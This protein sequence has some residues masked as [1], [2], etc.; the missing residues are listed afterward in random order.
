[1]DYMMLML[2]NK[3]IYLFYMSYVPEYNFEL[4][5]NAPTHNM[6]CLRHTL[7]EHSKA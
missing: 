3:Q 6:F 5:I 1:M 7:F 4:D 2:D